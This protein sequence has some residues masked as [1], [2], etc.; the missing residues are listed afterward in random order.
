[1]H[2][3]ASQNCLRAWVCPCWLW[4]L[5]KPYY[6]ARLQFLKCIIRSEG[7]LVTIQTLI[8]S[9]SLIYKSLS[10]IAPISSLS[11][12]ASLLLL[13]TWD[14]IKFHFTLFLRNSKAPFSITVIQFLTLSHLSCDLEYIFFFFRKRTQ[15]AYFL[16]PYAFGMFFLSVSFTWTSVYR[17]VEFMAFFAIRIFFPQSQ[18]LLCFLLTFILLSKDILFNWE[19]FFFP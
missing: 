8:P 10:T 17:G 5:G 16:R 14:I 19:L 18:K 7:P 4:A 15:V 13:I 3:S 2:D 1:M 9:V 12:Q 6:S 11:A